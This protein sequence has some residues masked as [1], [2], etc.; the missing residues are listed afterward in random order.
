MKKFQAGDTFIAVV[1]GVQ[2]KVK[3]VSFNSIHQVEEYIVQWRD[4]PGEEFAYSCEECDS[5]WRLLQRP[6]QY[7]GWMAQD[8]HDIKIQT[9]GPVKVQCNGHHHWIEIG[10][11]FTK[12]VCKYC[13]TEKKT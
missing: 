8:S 6:P 4:R 7:V 3:A 13:D 12:E 9:G 2:G 5:E 10:F 11:N 1:T